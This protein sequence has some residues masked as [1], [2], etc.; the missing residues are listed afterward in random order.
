ME[1]IKPETR[2]CRGPLCEGLEKPVTDFSPK[3]TICKKCNCHNTKEYYKKND[4]P[5]RKFKNEIKENSKCVQCGISDI[6]VLEFDHNKGVK[7]INICKSFSKERIK[8]ELEHTQVLC[9]WCHRLKTRQT[10]DEKMKETDKIFTITDRPTSIEDGRTCVG[11]ICKGQLQYKTQFYNSKKKSYCKI[12]WSWIGREKRLKNYNFLL[13]LKLSA[14]EC[15][16]C[17]KEVTSNNTTCFDYDHI[18]PKTK[19]T[20]LATYVRLNY[21]TT[22]KMIE[23]SKKCR[24][25]CCNCHKIHTAHQLN[26]KMTETIDKSDT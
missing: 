1:D 18:D 21:D 4:R 5:Y 22:E 11:A 14:K 7:N 20:T 26:Y 3:L 10:M 25:L 19:T 15:A 8:S 2:I 17:N 23:E 6:R 12:C 9:T 16:L 13:E 24:L